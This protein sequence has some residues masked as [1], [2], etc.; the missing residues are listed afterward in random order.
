MTKASD[1][2]FGVVRNDSSDELITCFSSIY[3]AA[4]KHRLGFLLQI[5]LYFFMPLNSCFK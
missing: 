3:R 4:E 1:H 2:D 5:E